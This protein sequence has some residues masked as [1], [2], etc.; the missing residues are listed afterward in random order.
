M[1][2]D[3]SGVKN[4]TQSSNSSF[5]DFFPAWSPDG[6]YIAYNRQDRFGQIPHLYMMSADGA[7]PTLLRRYT[8]VPAWEPRPMS[9]AVS[10]L[11]WGRVKMTLD[12]R[13]QW[14]ATASSP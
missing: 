1:N 9:T 8:L 2:A 6:R 11:S 3:G 13:G 7:D 5:G 14:Q 10:V 12:R 4:L